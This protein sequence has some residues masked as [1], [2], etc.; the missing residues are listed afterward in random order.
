M[1]TAETAIKEIDP[2]DAALCAEFDFR[3][4]QETDIDGWL[5]KY[6]MLNSRTAFAR[7]S[8]VTGSGWTKSGKS[9][10]PSSSTVMIWMPP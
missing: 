5:P 6:R 4:E 9:S 10:R 3:S 8:P 7:R 2:E 1:T